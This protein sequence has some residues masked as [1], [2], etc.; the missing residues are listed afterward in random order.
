[1]VPLEIPL[2]YLLSGTNGTKIRQQMMQ[3]EYSEGNSV[4]A[5]K[6]T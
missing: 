4:N 6:V 5:G 3:A 2:V 1:M